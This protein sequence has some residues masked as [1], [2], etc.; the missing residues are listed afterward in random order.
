MAGI[1]KRLQKGF[2]NP[3]VVFPFIQ[4]QF[5]IFQ[6]LLREK[7]IGEALTFI[8]T[9]TGFDTYTRYLRHRSDD[10]ELTK[11]IVGYEMVLDVNDTGLSQ[12][13]ILRGS[14]EEQSGSRFRAELTRLKS[15]LDEDVTVLDIGANVGYFVLLEA[16]VLGERADIYAIEPHPENVTRLTQNIERN[17]LDI[18]ITTAAIGAENRTGTL[19]A[20][21]RSSNKHRLGRPP[22]AGDIA[23]TFEV[24]V[25]ALDS[26]LERRSI[27][28][29]SV[30]VLRMDVDGHEAA[31]LRGAETVLS[32]DSPMLLS[33]EFHPAELT[34]GAIAEMVETLEVNGFEVVTGF[35]DL[36]FGAGFELEIA[37]LEDLSGIELDGVQLLLRR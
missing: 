30:N 20:S 11:Q 26:Y 16:S 21:D 34:S 24:S 14:R 10:D 18:D 32:V 27:P 4:G 15:E 7:R 22:T 5:R 33:M 2:S 17:N 8:P 37:R 19:Y 29:A 23:R 3:E 31:I 6:Q 9:I 28:P 1:R 12:D 35:F 25:L 13:L 36:P